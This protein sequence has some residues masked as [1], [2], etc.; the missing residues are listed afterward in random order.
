MRK[1]VVLA[2]IIDWIGLHINRRSTARSRRSAIALDAPKTILGLKVCGKRT[3]YLPDVSLVVVDT[4]CFSQASSS[5][6]NA[7]SPP[8]VSISQNRSIIE[9]SEDK[10]L[11]PPPEYAEAYDDADDKYGTNNPTYTV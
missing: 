2:G 4:K 9:S 10:L 5:A 3:T 8:I 7:G 1:I 6:D 11:N